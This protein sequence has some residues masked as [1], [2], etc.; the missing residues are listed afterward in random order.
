[1]NVKSD[2]D[3]GLNEVVIPKNKQGSYGPKDYLHSLELFTAPLESKFDVASHFISS[4]DGEAHSGN[5][6]KY[7]YIQEVF[8]SN[9]A[10]IEEAQIRCSQYD[11]MDIFMVPMVHDKNA[12]H[13]A[14]MWNDDELFL[15]WYSF[16]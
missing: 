12:S 1:M 8:V 3:I 4:H 5:K 6:I 14:L 13:P 16:I 2:I 15:C 11:F 7:Q 10:K 9:V